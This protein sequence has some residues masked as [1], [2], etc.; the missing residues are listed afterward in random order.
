MIPDSTET[1]QPELNRRT[2]TDRC[3]DYRCGEYPAR[4]LLLETRCPDC[5]AVDPPYQ[6]VLE[7][8]PCGC[9][10]PFEA[11]ADAGG[12]PDCGGVADASVIGRYYTCPT[13]R[14][15]FDTPE[16][17]LTAA[18]TAILAADA[19]ESDFEWNPTL[20]ERR[21][22]DAERE[23]D[24]EQISAESQEMAAASTESRGSEP[25]TTAS[26]SN[27]PA[28]AGGGGGGD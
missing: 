14:S 20:L 27:E 25:Q 16:Y 19:A 26:E 7:H 23:R 4:K 8:D 5:T 10:R 13:C 22:Q 3:G 2:R 18:E 24:A 21:E 15:S 11:F 6:H 28:V 12:C 1:T 9:I 17:R